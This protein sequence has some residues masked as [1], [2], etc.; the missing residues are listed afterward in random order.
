MQFHL[1]D[2]KLTTMKMQELDKSSF[3]DFISQIA[4]KNPKNNGLVKSK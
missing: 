4:M 3:I 1:I 2:Q